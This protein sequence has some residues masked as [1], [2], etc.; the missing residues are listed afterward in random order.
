V[1]V[2]DAECNEGSLW[3][4]VMFA[5]HHRLSQLIVL[6]D[7]NGQQATGYT[8]EVLDLSPLAARF[9][10]FGW[11]A[12]EVDGHDLDGL[13]RTLDALDTRQGPPHVLCARTTFGRGVSFMQGLIKWHYWPMSDDEYRVAIAEVEG[14]P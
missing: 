14:R 8:R 13:R 12:R 4:A 2:S 6:V 11:D 1:L 3:E 5:A 10:A 7:C 9:G